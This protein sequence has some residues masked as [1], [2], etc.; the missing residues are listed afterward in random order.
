[1]YA[2][3]YLSYFNVFV[4]VFIQY[5]QIEI[6]NHTTEDYSVIHFKPGGWFG[7]ELNKVEGSIFS[8]E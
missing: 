6:T 3:F 1:M 7:K 2:P 4:S 8:A 5:G